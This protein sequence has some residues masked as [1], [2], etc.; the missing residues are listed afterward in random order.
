M[1]QPQADNPQ[2]FSP[3]ASHH[4]HI[5]QS[6]QEAPVILS[7]S[8]LILF[9]SPSPCCQ[10]TFLIEKW[11]LWMSVLVCQ[12]MLEDWMVTE[13]C[14]LSHLLNLSQKRIMQCLGGLSSSSLG[15]SR[16]M[17]SGQLAALNPGKA[18]E[19]PK[20]EAA[21]TNCAGLEKKEGGPVHMIAQ[22]C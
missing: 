1:G 5:I 4:I 6:S 19:I 15:S 21:F 3:Y 16:T 7:I 13:L 11:F 12:Q 14:H 22:Q 18:I 2:F 17:V 8:F 9:V 10:S 20:V